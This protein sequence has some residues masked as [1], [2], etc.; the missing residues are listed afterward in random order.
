MKSGHHHNSRN[1]SGVSTTIEY[2]IISGVL[3]CLFVVVLLL[4]NANIMQGPAE[5]LEYSAF[6]DIGNG[7]ST[8]IVDVYSIAP[9][10]GTI[11]TSFDI[12]DDVAGQDYFVVI[13]EDTDL[14]NQDVS[15]YRGT[16]T[17]TISLAGIGATRPVTG[18][19]TGRGMNR[20]RYDSRGV[21]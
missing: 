11:A 16:I 15:V 1:E 7:V 8:R 3:L 2:V 6:T 10:N 9:A 21:S 12:P 17:S 13:G 18:N 19:T 20:I 14:I 5:R 4:V